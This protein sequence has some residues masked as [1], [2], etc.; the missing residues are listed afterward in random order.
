MNQLFTSTDSQ[1]LHSKHCTK[2]RELK[3]FSAFLKEPNRDDGLR[4]E[5]KA[6]RSAYCK[7][8]RETMRENHKRFLARNPGKSYQY[9]AAWNAKH[10]EQV[11]TQWLVSRAVRRGDMVREPCWVCGAEAEA[12]H[13]HYG[14]PLMVS[15]LCRKHH[16]E[17][18]GIVR[19][20]RR[21]GD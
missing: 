7:S 6:C 18:H 11:K 15:W 17:A 4:G 16:L 13:P 10:K 20:I 12:H 2:C 8:R 5:C 21:D 19:A 14:E 9:T 1:T 3:P